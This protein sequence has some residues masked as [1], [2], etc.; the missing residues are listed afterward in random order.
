MNSIKVSFDK[1]RNNKYTFEV[2][3]NGETLFKKEYTADKKYT[4]TDLVENQADNF[5]AFVDYVQDR[6]NVELLDNP[7]FI[8]DNL[9]QLKKFMGAKLQK[10]FYEVQ[11]K[12]FAKYKK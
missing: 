10:Q 6:V 9:D 8:F 11:N 1:N 3:Q 12:Y 5:S 2:V 7:N 4:D